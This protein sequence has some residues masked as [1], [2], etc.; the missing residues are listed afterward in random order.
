MVIKTYGLSL[1]IGLQQG[2]RIPKANVANR[3]SIAGNRVGGQVLQS[4]IGRFL[5]PIQVVG[6]AS[7]FNVILQIG[8]FQPEFVWLHHEFLNG[9]RH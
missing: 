6:I 7:E 8:S 2:T 3:A 5:D 4:R 1:L 9:N